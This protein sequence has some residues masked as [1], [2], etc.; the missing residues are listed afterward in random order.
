MPIYLLFFHII[1]SSGHKIKKK[2]TTKQVTLTDNSQLRLAKVPLDFTQLFFFKKNTIKL[3]YIQS[4]VC[5]FNLYFL[6]YKYVCIY[7]HLYIYVYIYIFFSI[8]FYPRRLNIVPST[9]Q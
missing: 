2:V 4:L 5:F 8:M 6:I 9:M 1:R 7:T 3:P